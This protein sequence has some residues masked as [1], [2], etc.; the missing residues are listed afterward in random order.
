MKFLSQAF[1]FPD[2]NDLDAVAV[3]AIRRDISMDL[4]L[5]I[6]HGFY[7]Y[8]LLLGI[9]WFTST[10]PADHPRVWWTVASWLIGLN[11]VRMFLVFRREQLYDRSPKAWCISIEATTLAV[12]SGFGLLLTCTGIWYDLEN[13]N[14]QATLVF[15]IGIAAG[16][17]IGLTPCYRLM[18]LNPIVLFVPGTLVAACQGGDKGIGVAIAGGVFVAF[19]LGQG[20]ALHQSYIGLNWEQAVSRK[21]SG[22]LEQ[23]RRD[24]E[25]ASEAKSQFLA[26]L[27]HEIRTPMNGILGMARLALDDNP[28]P[29]V[30]ESIET[31]EQCATGLLDI[32]ND[33]LD[34]S[35]LDAGKLVLDSVP[36]SPRQLLEE[37]TKLLAPQA[38]VKK[39][40]LELD[41]PSDLIVV[42][43]DML[44]LRQ[45]LV[46]LIG[47]AIKFTSQGSVRVSCKAM[48]REPGLWEL[49]FAV[50]DTGIGI[51]PGQQAMIFEAF[52]QADGSISRRFGGTGLGLAI[53]SRIVDAMGGAIKVDSAPGKGSQFSFSCCFSEGV[54]QSLVHL[55]R[56]VELPRVVPAL[57]ILVAEDNA[58]N[59]RLIERL[60][61]RHDHR[62]V[63]ATNG[64]E[65]LDAATH[66]HFDMILMD[67]S[68]PELDGMEAARQLRLWESG[69]GRS[70]TPIL[71]ITANAMKGDRER[72]AA[73]G[74]DGYLAK[75]FTAN[76]LYGVIEQFSSLVVRDSSYSK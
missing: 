37:A 44:R 34:F 65:A 27:S 20:K 12:A 10:L 58:V 2:S 4:A 50:A 64:R 6:R 60:L 39:I 36:F 40:A 73:V 75:P 30:R 70:H 67:I 21:R 43:G 57:T 19:L 72:F 59:Q 74:M 11:F 52:H 35:K 49:A 56:A 17:L 29:A 62:V 47:N 53:C 63:L 9:L 22:E 55:H 46:N 1:L 5:R 68:M 3:D 76:Q 26:N 41:A 7:A 45:V 25:A 61:T 51:E 71:A 14:L 32:L 8:P 42:E 33:M 66:Q 16:S 48:L 31:L 28:S 24:A 69:T 15:N 54:A 38:R 13:W 18:V 23:S